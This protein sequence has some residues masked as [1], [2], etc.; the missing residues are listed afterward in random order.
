MITRNEAKDVEKYLQT[1][2][3]FLFLLLREGSEEN[4]AKRLLEKMSFL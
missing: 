1:L 2:L 4:G 3:H